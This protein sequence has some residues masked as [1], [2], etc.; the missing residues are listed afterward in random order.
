LIQGT[1]SAL[2]FISTTMSGFPVLAK[3]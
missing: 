2:P 1:A 3:A